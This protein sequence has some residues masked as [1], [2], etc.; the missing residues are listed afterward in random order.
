MLW[1]LSFVPN[2]MNVKIIEFSPEYTCDAVSIWNEIIE[3]G[4]AFPQLDYLNNENGKAFFEEQSFT[5][6]ALDE[7]SHN[8]VGLYILHPNNVGRCGHIANASYAVAS[9]Y[10]GM[11]VGEI[12]V[13]HCLDKA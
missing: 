10:R 11:R 9:S 4:V 6:L 1:L 5:G 2:N 8:I 7:E 13:T 12:L 3:E